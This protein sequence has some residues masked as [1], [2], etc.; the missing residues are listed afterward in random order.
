[1]A[2]I[3]IY[4]KFY[5]NKFYFLNLYHNFVMILP[6]VVIFVTTLIILHFLLLYLSVSEKLEETNARIIQRTENIGENYLISGKLISRTAMNDSIE[7][8]DKKVTAP[9][10]EN[11]V[12][13]QSYAAIDQKLPINIECLH[14]P[15]P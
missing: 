7:G 14:F 15:W 6:G 5:V 3:F 8:L 9:G 1:M 11:T 13:G 10:Y 2:E 12:N 4:L